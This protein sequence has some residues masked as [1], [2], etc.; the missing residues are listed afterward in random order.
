MAGEIGFDVNQMIQQMNMLME[1][2][3]PYMELL[4]IK[5]YIDRID[6]KPKDCPDLCVDYVW[7]I[8][9]ETKYVCDKLR[10][11]LEKEQQEQ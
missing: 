6:L 10:E 1:A 7:R 4:G 2:L 5:L 9:C 3:R 11:Q 8:K